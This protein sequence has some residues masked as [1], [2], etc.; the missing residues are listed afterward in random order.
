MCGAVRRENTTWRA[1]E[2][3]EEGE[4]TVDAPPVRYHVFRLFAI[5]HSNEFF[6]PCASGQHASHEAAVDLVLA[7]EVVELRVE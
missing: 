1:V 6:T 2:S 7:D 5:T 4:E 3:R